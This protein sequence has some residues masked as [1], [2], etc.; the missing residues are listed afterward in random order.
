MHVRALLAAGAVAL[1][2]APSAS[3]QTKAAS[4]PQ[5]AAARPLTGAAWLGYEMGDLDGLQ[6]RVDAELPLQ[7]LS[8]QVDLSFVGALGYSRL[9]DSASGLD[10]TA[11]V[12]KIV[13]A[14]RFTLT[15]DPQLSV[16]GDAGLGLYYSSVSYDPQVLDDDSTFNL[17][18]R[19]AAGGLYTVNPRAKVGVQLVLDPMLGD[20]DDTTFTLL[21]G[22][23][24]RL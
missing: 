16:F 17:M 4:T 10:V 7:K 8:P 2:A 19:F 23:T 21:A 22:V 18:L 15:V 1:V 3:A 5:P 11:N 13:P 14:A 12:L 9:G 20:Y 6:L 24:Y